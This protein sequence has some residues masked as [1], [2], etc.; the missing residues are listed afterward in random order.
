MWATLTECGF[1]LQ[2]IEV[3]RDDSF[4]PSQG[5]LSLKG[6]S[7]VQTEE[8]T[9]DGKGRYPPWSMRPSLKEMA[10]ELGID[11][12]ELVACFKRDISSRKIADKFGITP[13]TAEILKEHF[14]K[15]GIGSVTGGD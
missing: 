9:G 3:R 10:E 13:Q 12:D 4:W 5:K 6:G 1:L 8:R 14:V 15:Y 11:H 7:F 2:G